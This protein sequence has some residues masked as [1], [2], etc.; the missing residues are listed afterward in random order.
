MSTGGVSKSLPIISSDTTGENATYGNPMNMPMV[1]TSGKRTI[2]EEEPESR[3]PI[4]TLLASLSSNGDSSAGTNMHTMKTHLLLQGL[5]SDNNKM[6]NKVLTI[7]DPV[8]IRTTLSKLP[9]TAV[10]PLLEYFNNY[11]LPMWH[12][13]NSFSMWLRELLVQQNS[14]ITS[15]PQSQKMFKSFIRYADIRTASMSKLMMLQGRLRLVKKLA[16][17]RNMSTHKNDKVYSPMIRFNADSDS[18]DDMEDEDALHSNGEICN[19]F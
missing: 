17:S 2:D 18:E 12:Y 10:V 19:I 8:T 11:C 5:Q 4:S 13:K 6:V 1:Q 15:L 3:L 7:E 16:E 9:V 14:Y